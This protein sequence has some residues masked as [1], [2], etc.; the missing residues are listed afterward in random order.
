MSVLYFMATS[1]PIGVGEVKKFIPNDRGGFYIILSDEG[2]FRADAKQFSE[3]PSIGSIVT[4]LPGRRE[5]NA[6]RRIKQILFQP[7]AAC[8][9]K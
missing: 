6:P 3:L 7:E 1:F 2:R 5:A 9:L 8:E 4:F